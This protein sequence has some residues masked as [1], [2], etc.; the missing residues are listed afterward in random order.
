MLTLIG[1]LFVFFLYI[2]HWRANIYIQSIFLHRGAAHGMF[3]FKNELWMKFFFLVA[4]FILGPSYLSGRVYRILHLMHH[5]YA[6]EQNDPHKPYPGLF[7]VFK[8]LWKT[9]RRY[10]AIFQQRSH[11]DIDGRQVKI[12]Y[13]SRDLAIDWPF[14]DRML[15]NWPTR[16]MFMIL[17]SLGYYFIINFFGLPSFMYVMVIM[18]AIMAPLHGAIVNYYA[19]NYGEHK[20][21][22]PDTSRNM[23]RLARQILSLQG[24]LLHNNHHKFPASPDF[25]LGENEDGSYRFML[26]MDKV[27]IIQLKKPKPQ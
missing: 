23:P 26:W 4:F 3:K 25:S 12:D 27:G 13:P 9:A 19:H 6:D 21:D 14:F 2:L 16:V 18:H 7:G 24:E 20:Y 11:M 1:F 5:K 10:N 17:Y 15:H 8:T 22:T